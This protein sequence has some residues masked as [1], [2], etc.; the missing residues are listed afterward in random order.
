VPKIEPI[1]TIQLEYCVPCN[2]RN[3]AVEFADETLA[4]WGSLIKSLEFVPTG[5]GTFEVILNGEL[6]FSKWALGRH[7]KVGEL[8]ELI[9][10]R[11][12]PPQED[13]AYDHAPEKVDAQGFPVH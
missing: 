12:G 11:I 1:H 9:Q 13:Y 3:L 7:A 2:Y 4:R 10:E 8:M 5:W 6:I